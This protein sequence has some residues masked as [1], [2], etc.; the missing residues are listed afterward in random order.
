MEN[1][2]I[3]FGANELGKAAMAVLESN[4]VVIYGFLDDDEKLHNQTINEVAILGA[5]DDDGFLKF[6]GQ[7]CEAF[8]AFDNNKVR[9][10]TVEMLNKRRKVMPMNAIHQKAYVEESVHI[11]HGN[12]IN[13]GVIIAANAKVGSHC[14][15]HS[16]ATID[17][18][19]E[20]GDLVQVGAGSIINA[21][22]KIE[23]EAFIGSGVT[24]V[25]G[26]KIGKGA[27]VGAGSVVIA[28]V[29]AGKTVFGNPAA[30]VKS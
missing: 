30:E 6:I 19:S 4:G 9:K 23:D 3:I 12:F 22:V 16:N 10:A 21:E 15:I 5:T 8:V 27:R 14:I 17:Y 1:P 2:V 20:L 11:E 25:S 18:S 7:K 13:A 29:P 26:V 28:D 24:I